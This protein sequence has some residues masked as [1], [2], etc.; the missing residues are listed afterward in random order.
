MYKGRGNVERPTLYLYQTTRP[1]DEQL[2]RY[3]EESRAFS[4]VRAILLARGNP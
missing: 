1:G 4:E 2:R 3:A